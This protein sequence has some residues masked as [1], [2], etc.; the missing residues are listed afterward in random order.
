MIDRLFPLGGPV[1]EEDLVD[2][3]DF[4]S[5]LLTRLSD[6]QSVMLAG[7]R[8]IGKTSLALEVLRRLKKRQFYTAAVDLF[9]VSGRRDFA[10]AL[11][12]ACL[13]N[14]TGMKRTLATLKDRARVVAGGAK[15]SLKLQGLEISLGSLEKDPDAKILDYALDLPALLAERDKRP[16]VVFFDEFQEAARIAGG[17]IYKK[18]RSHFQIQKNVSYLFLGSKEGMM[19]TLFGSRK[20]AFYRFATVLPIPSVPEDAWVDYIVGKFA[21]RG[22]EAEEEPVREIVRLTGGHPQDTMSVCSEAYYALLETGQKVLTLDCVRLGYERAMLTLAPVFDEILDEL[23]RRP[24]VRR[25]LQQVAA[26]S[27]PYFESPNPNMAKR[28]VDLLI[29][30]GILERKRR[31]EYAFVEPMFRDYVL[32]LG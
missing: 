12:D 14:R 30:K 18:M 3:E 10:E 23:G 1:S 16:V 32:T 24:Q 11:I 5:S 13:E 31:G 25:V 17:E 26:G 20:H 21:R 8:R 2:R 4:I 6:G 9:R 22:I 28:A 7:P 29:R 19:E 15:L 27:G